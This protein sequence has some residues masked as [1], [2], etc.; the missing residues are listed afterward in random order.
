MEVLLGI[1]LAPVK[2]VVPL[3]NNTLV[4]LLDA[5]PVTGMLL[6]WRSL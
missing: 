5:Y 2:A 1:G 3:D 4:L 6:S